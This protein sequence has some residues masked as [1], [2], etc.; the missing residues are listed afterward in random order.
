M[1]DAELIARQAKRLAELEEEVGSLKH[2]RDK[3][4]LM[5]VGIGGP[6]NDNVLEF[7]AKQREFL[8]RL[9]SWLT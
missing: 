7:N 1:V 8:H 2:D 9:E 3:A 5:L 4:R 6:L